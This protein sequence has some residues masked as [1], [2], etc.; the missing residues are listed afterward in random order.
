MWSDD[1]CIGEAYQAE[2]PPF[3]SHPPVSASALD[4]LSVRA[5]KEQIRE[6]GL[7]ASDCVEKRELVELL[8][9]NSPPLAADAGVRGGVRLTGDDVEVALARAT[10]ALEV[11]R[12]G[13]GG[14]RPSPTSDSMR[15]PA[16]GCNRS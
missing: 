11:A 2:L 13:A 14:P 5:L 9:A 10:A 1:E 12:S 15:L 8:V 3:E 7:D 4:A 6:R 16:S